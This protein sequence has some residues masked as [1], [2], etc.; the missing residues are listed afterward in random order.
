ML[1]LV[2]SALKCSVHS[3]S[4]RSTWDVGASRNKC[5]RLHP[6]LHVRLFLFAVY[7]ICEPRNIAP[8]FAHTLV[9][10]ELPP[11]HVQYKPPCQCNTISRSNIFTFIVLLC[12]LLFFGRLS[13]FRENWYSF[14]VCLPAINDTICLGKYLSAFRGWQA[15]VINK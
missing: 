12:K 2:V 11:D 9:V 3:Q 8:S 15:V 6:F 13:K 5:L 1:V 10:T 14:S 7:Y 4:C